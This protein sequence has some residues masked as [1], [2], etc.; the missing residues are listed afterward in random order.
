MAAAGGVMNIR[1][2]I[3]RVFL[4]L[5]VC[6]G[7]GALVTCAR[8]FPYETDHYHFWGN[9]FKSSAQHD[10]D[11][12]GQG[13]YV[14]EWPVDAKGADFVKEACAKASTPSTIET[15]KLFQSDN[16]SLTSRQWQA[17]GGALLAALLAFVAV[18]LL[19][20]SLDWVLAGFQRPTVPA[21]SAATRPP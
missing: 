3:R 13:R 17:V 2:G 10:A 18:Y 8:W 20:R 11:P 5:G 9:A 7:L 4:I 14:F 12:N 21:P 15:C 16:Q 6:A 19:W 1:E